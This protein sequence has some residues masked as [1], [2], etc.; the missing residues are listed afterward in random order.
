M[1]IEHVHLN[2]HDGQSEA[3]ELAFRQAKEAIAPMQGLNAV[4][5]IKHIENEHA[6]ILLIFWDRLEDH[7]VGFRCSDAYQKWSALLHPFF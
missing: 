3:F 5:L 1:I 6:Y 2:I 7:T 4:Q